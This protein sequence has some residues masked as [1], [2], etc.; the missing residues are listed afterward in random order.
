MAPNGA[1]SQLRTEIRIPQCD[2]MTSSPSLGGTPIEEP[3][4]IVPLQERPLQGPLPPTEMPK[5][6][7]PTGVVVSN[8][9]RTVQ[10]QT[11]LI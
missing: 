1:N 2:G 7:T 5:D 9:L 10:Q 11:S 4:K 3:V 8:L 6:A